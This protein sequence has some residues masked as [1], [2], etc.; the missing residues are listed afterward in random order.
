MS[1]APSGATCSFSSNLFQADVAASPIAVFVDVTAPAVA[2]PVIT[3]STTTDR[4]VIITWTASE[5]LSA[6]RCSVDS[7]AFNPC[8]S[9]QQLTLPEGT[10]TL[11]V[12]ATD[13]SGNVGLSAKPSFRIIDTQIVSGPPAFS[14]SHTAK[15]VFS[16]LTGVA[17]DCSL[18]GAAFTDCGPKGPN[19][20]GSMNLSGLSEGVHTFQ[21]RGKDGA[22]FDRVAAARVW[23]VDVTPPV[24]A[25]DPLSGPGEGALQAATTRRSSSL[26]TSRRHSSARSR[27]CVYR[28]RK[29]QDGQ[30]PEAWRPQLQVR[31]ADRAGNVQ[32]TPAKR[33]WTV[34]NLSANSEVDADHDGF[35][36]GQDCNDHNPNIHPGRAGDPGQQ[37]RRELRRHRRAVPDDLR[38]ALPPAGT[39]T[40]ST[41]K[42][43]ALR[44]DAS[45]G[46]HV[47]MTCK[48]KKCP[49]K[50]QEAQARPRRASFNAAQEA[51]EAPAP[52]HAGAD[53]GRDRQR[54]ELQHQGRPLQA[55]EGQDPDGKA[56][57]PPGGLARPRSSCS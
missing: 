54:Q 35:S 8:S 28:L 20:Q 49:F 1:R 51:Q 16:T 34:A 41:L 2:G 15:F 11:Q 44:H 7:G 45:P 48:G 17:F 30:Q 19:G 18:D 5:A 10:H 52:F 42:L 24:A 32:P 47:T 14:N 27:G 13:L 12:Q 9:G 22:D 46:P 50:T 31:A 4:A 26:R 3:Y 38:R 43:T 40:G 57:V 6:V 37:D 25:L 56:L 29:P 33:S 23:T 36:S 53:A 21:V 39:C 55:Q